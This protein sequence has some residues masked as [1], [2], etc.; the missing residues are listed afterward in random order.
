MM[1]G[2]A[3][4]KIGDTIRNKEYGQDGMSGESARRDKTSCG[5]Q[6]KGITILIHTV[7][8]EK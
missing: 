5:W 3:A 8:S 6:I 1:D 2:Q 7:S 4:Q